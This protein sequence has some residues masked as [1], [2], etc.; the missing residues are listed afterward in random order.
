MKIRPKKIKCMNCNNNGNIKIITLLLSLIGVGTFYV[1]QGQE[2]KGTSTS[3][4]TSIPASI[5][6]TY[7][8]TKEKYIELPLTSLEESKKSIEQLGVISVE[9]K[10]EVLSISEKKSQDTLPQSKTQISTNEPEISKLTNQMVEN[11]R[12]ITAE[13]DKLHQ[14]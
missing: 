5:E 4:L 3:L 7:V 12:S 8:E 9:K 14:K 6:K 13:Y 11:C 1:S 10:Q 2:I